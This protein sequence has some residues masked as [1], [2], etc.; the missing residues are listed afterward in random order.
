MMHIPD[1]AS[2]CPAR[3]PDAGVHPPEVGVVRVSAEPAVSVNHIS[4]E[5]NLGLT[6]R[7][8]SMREILGQR[9]RHPLRG[10]GRT[11]QRF[12]A[13]DDVSFDVARGEVVGVIGRNG[14][15]KSTLLKILSRITP[16]SAGHIEMAA[17]V[18]S[19]LEVG[20]GFHPELTGI[21]NV[22]LNGAILGMSPRE[23]D[24]R[25]EE[26]LEFAEVDKFLQT[27]VKRYSSG[28]RVRL[29]FAVAAHLDPEVL[30]VDE[31]LSVGDL[32]F[33]A[34]CLDKMRALTSEEGRTVLYVSHNLVT[35]EH[36][37]LRALLLVD[38]RLVFDGPAEET[39]AR[40]VHLIP[41]AEPGLTPGVFD[42]SAA[43]RS[44]GPSVLHEVF[45]RLEFRPD[46]GAPST[47]IRMGRRVRIEILVEGLDAIPDPAVTI[48]VG[49]VRTATLFR[50]SSRMIPL[51]AAHARC[52]VEKIVLDLPSLPLTPGD[53]ELHVRLRDG[54]STIVDHVRRAAEFTVVP[55]DVHGNGYQFSSGDGDFFV[56]WTW[57][58][59]PSTVDH[60]T[61][62]VHAEE[63]RSR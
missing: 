49:S 38:G 37:C 18:G 56:P 52:P 11:R 50:I 20:T 5:Y 8:S 61:P 53:Y 40:Y 27:P 58:I 24:R 55:G 9:I 17:S 43:D 60:A 26:I 42:L 15:G 32:S 47:T 46:G 7:S 4:K 10:A 36:L 2:T 31:V 16:P 30:I 23:I 59:R 54:A 14:A 28:M 25:L 6:G 34:K 22:Y 19:L 3:P 33:Q 44:S 62:D 48:T 41:R 63:V 57:E 45:K 51:A 13:L 39:V 29:A 1:G 35:V 21:E 12:L